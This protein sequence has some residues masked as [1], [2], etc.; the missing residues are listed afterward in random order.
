MFFK[1]VLLGNVHRKVFWEP[2][3]VI[4][5][6]RG[7]FV[8]KTVLLKMFNGLLTSSRYNTLVLLRTV[9]RK[10]L[11]EIKNGSSLL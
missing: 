5:W 11:W 4:L 1:V 3:M 2:I 6:H 10:V 9:H 8:F 7:T